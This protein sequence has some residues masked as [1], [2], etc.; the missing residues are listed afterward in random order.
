MSGS[1]DAQYANDYDAMYT[2][3]FPGSRRGARDLSLGVPP[4]GDDGFDF[5]SA[6]PPVIDYENPRTD[7]RLGDVRNPALPTERMARRSRISELASPPLVPYEVLSPEDVLGPRDPSK[8]EQ[9]ELEAKRGGRKLS[10]RQQRFYDSIPEG[11]AEE[12]MSKKQRKAYRN[13]QAIDAGKPTS[14]ERK[15]ANFQTFMGALGRSAAVAAPNAPHWQAAARAIDANTRRYDDQRDDFEE[16]RLAEMER[17]AA[18]RE[19][20]EKAYAELA[21][22]PMV[23]FRGQQMTRSEAEKMLERE[24]KAKIN[25]QRESRLARESENRQADREADNARD[26][27]KMQELAAYRNRLLKLREQGAIS[28]EQYREGML[29]ARRDELELRK[30]RPASRGSDLPPWG[31]IEAAEHRAMADAGL[32]PKMDALT[33]ELKARAKEILEEWNAIRESYGEAE[34]PMT[35]VEDEGGG[36]LLDEP[37]PFADLDL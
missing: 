23:N 32:D 24:G 12:D 2:S 13:Q 15:M 3:L 37:D 8:W 11:M 34:E 28:Q 22:D 7:L 5:G 33:P 29:Q 31:T 10:K 30:N 17:V 25:A 35:P 1:P 4:P 16:S 19:A 6:N 21:S 36:D 20:E 27:R 26:E 14:G 18:E 9:A